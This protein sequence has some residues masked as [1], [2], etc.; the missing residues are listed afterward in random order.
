M[1]LVTRFNLIFASG[2]QTAGP[3][4]DPTIVRYAV[5]LTTGLFIN[6]VFCLTNP[7]NLL[8]LVH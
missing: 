6:M 5:H 2:L 8:A 1:D 7:S 3:K 4:L